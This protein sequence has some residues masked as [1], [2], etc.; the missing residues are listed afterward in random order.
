MSAAANIWVGQDG[1]KLGPYTEESLRQLFNEG[2]I[3]PDTL[4]WYSGLNEW[5]TV[6]KS[7]PDWAT[8]RLAP[9]IPPRGNAPKQSAFAQQRSAGFDVQEASKWHRHMVL[10]FLGGILGVVIASMLHSEPLVGLVALVSGLAIVFGAYKLATAIGKNGWL[11]AILTL[12]PI[13]VVSLVAF[14]L[15]LNESNKKFKSEGYKVDFLG[16]IKS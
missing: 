2:K 16:G 10:W 7:Y 12:I 1:Q 11:W 4:I 14:L 8:I 13:P 5:T 9:N 6:A 15:L 3:K